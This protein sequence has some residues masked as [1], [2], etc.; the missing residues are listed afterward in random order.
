VG[1]NLLSSGISFLGSG[2]WLRG[3]TG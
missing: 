1:I 2:L 3:R